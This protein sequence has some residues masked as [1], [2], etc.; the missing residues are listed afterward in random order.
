M[1]R[2]HLGIDIAIDEWAPAT[3]KRIDELKAKIPKWY[4][5][6]EGEGV[7]MRA[8]QRLEQ[9]YLAEGWEDVIKGLVNRENIVFSHNDAQ[10]NNILASLADATKIVLI[11]YEYGMW[12]PMYYDLGN[13]LNEWICDNAHPRDPGIHY[14]FDNW[15]A[16][17]EI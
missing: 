8:L 15:P 12:N 13:Y 6:P 4:T 14:Y 1:D 2:N 16:E 5:D 3:L 7:I 11:D 17:S 10:E 9:T